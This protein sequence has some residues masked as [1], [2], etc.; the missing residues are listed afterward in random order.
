[1]AGAWAVLA[2]L[3]GCGA[4]EPEVKAEPKTV[5]D[6]FP[7]AVGEA[8]V[9]MQ[10]AVT[11]AEMQQGLM[12]RTDLQPNQGMLFVYRGTTQMSFWMRNT[13]TALDIGFFTSDG[14]LREVYKLH[15][16]DERPVR[17]RRDDLQYALEVIQG[18]FAEMG[19]KPGDQLDLAAV[20]QALEDRGFNPSGIRGLDT[21]E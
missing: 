1:M 10:L 9:D 18:G 5:K 21:I 15:P 17:S 3:S 4:P 8:K 19:I 20:S 12:G 11:P 6:W 14:V 13:P 16:F 7:I 2:T